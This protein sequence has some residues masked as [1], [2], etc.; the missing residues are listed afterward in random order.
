M[1]NQGV[2][3]AEFDPR[4][5][6][7]IRLEVRR[8]REHINLIA[9]ENHSSPRVRE[10]LGSLLNDKYAEG[11]PGRRY[12]GG[13]QYVDQVE[14]LAI[15]RVKRLFSAEYANVQPHSGSQAN[16]AVLMALLKPGDTLLGM[17]LTHGGHLTHG[18]SVSFSGKLYR[19]IAYGVDEKGIID[20]QQVEQLAQLHRP[21]L[22]IAGFSAYS[23]QADWRRFRT[24]ADSVGA[25]LMADI[26]HVAGLI[27]AGLYDSPVP[28]ADVVTTTTHKTLRGPRGGVILARD[29][30]FARDKK[31]N[32]AIFPGLQGGP[33][34]HVIAAKAVAFQEALQPEFKDYQQQVI[35][36]ARAMVRVLQQRGFKIVSG[37]TDNHLFLVDLIGQG[38]SGKAGEHALND[39]HITLNKNMVPGDFRPASVS[40]GLR[41][42][43]PAVTT[44]GF[45]EAEVEQVAHWIADVLWAPE[46]VALAQQIKSAVIAL[47]QRFPIYAQHWLSE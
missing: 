19:A 5:A 25:W 13:C 33:L 16:A 6:Q 23:R 37:G 14:E 2:T 27:A 40:S 10:A 7:A 24:I 29:A 47:C 3:L 31:L 18:A 39:T 21:K 8:Q 41:I 46:N 38:I 30:A 26:A 32:A 9:S 22:I 12:Y 17:N 28:F 4:L 36:N 20:Y 42:G 34:M 15:E 44:R 35:Q 45:K 43:T 1:P 11:Y